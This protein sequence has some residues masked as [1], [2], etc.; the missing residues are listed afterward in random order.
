M[1]TTTVARGFI[2][3]VASLLG[4]VAVGCSSEPLSPEEAAEIGVTSQ[5]LSVATGTVMPNSPANSD[6]Q[7]AAS[8]IINDN[9]ASGG[10]NY[11]L[12]LGGYDSAGTTALA[13]GWLYDGTNWTHTDAVSNPDIALVT[14]RGQAKMI[15]VPG[16]PN[17]CL[18]VGGTTTLNGTAVDKVD[19]VTFT[20]GVLTVAPVAKL[21]DGRKHFALSTCGSKVIVFGGIDDNGAITRS[22]ETWA[23]TDTNSANTWSGNFS[24]QLDTERYDFG[25]ARDVVSSNDVYVLAGGR[26]SGGVISSIELIQSSSSCTSFTTTVG[27]NSLGTVRVGNVVF[28]KATGQSASA[29]VYVSAAGFKPGTAPNLPTATDDLTVDWTATPPTVSRAAGAFSLSLGTHSPALVALASGNFMLVGGNDQ[30][31]AN[32]SSQDTT[33][34]VTDAIQKFTVGSGFTDDDLPSGRFG[35]AAE[36]LGSEVIVATG[37][38]QATGAVT[39][40]KAVVEITP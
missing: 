14:P 15:Q 11:M 21:N 6:R 1:K 9:T 30:E 3:A 22:V 35:H 18:L 10:V 37:G 27:G 17:K 20:N 25:L 16:A 12:V 29:S 13:D 24:T 38:V 19:L 40:T 39:P 4:V 7:F 5:A 8:C 32:L 28:P 36:L 34:I 23:T 2:G 26:S 31:F 33:G